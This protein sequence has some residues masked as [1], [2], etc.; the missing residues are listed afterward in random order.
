MYTWGRGWTH[1]ER[2]RP[3]SVTLR[4]GRRRF[5]GFMS[6]TMR[7]RDG[8]S[9]GHAR[10][11]TPTTTTRSARSW[12]RAFS[13]SSKSTATTSDQIVTDALR[14]HGEQLLRGSRGKTALVRPFR[15]WPARRERVV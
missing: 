7:R 11:D 3:A 13:I 12:N 1:K 2:L 14:D 8:T 10:A 6:P 5:A 9:L 15:A 4:P